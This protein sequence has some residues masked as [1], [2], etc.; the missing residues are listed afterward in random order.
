MSGRGE[1]DGAGEMDGTRE[2]GGM[3]ILLTRAPE[4]DQALAEI[5]R[6]RGHRVFALPCVR[7]AALDDDRALGDTLARLTADD[8]LVVTSR[9]GARAVAA[10]LAGRRCAASVVAFGSA[11][12]A[13]LAE[14]GLAPRTLAAASGAELGEVIALPAGSIVLAR[15]DHALGDLPAILRRRGAAVRELVAYRT[16]P[17]ATGDTARIRAAL[18]AGEIDAA[19]LGSLTAVDALVAA[20][21][22]PA[23]SRI[24]CV[25]LGPTTARHATAAGLR[26]RAADAPTARAVA[27]VIG[28]LV[29]VIHATRN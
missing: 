18:E 16:M 27:N 8:I 4:N 26:A 7:T 1:V 17:A 24:L 20:L 9:A 22:V 29:E 28:D 23:L 3:G 19:V 10:A 15:S 14:R 21:G 5:L 12:A 2:M 6:G 25:A 13:A 11:T